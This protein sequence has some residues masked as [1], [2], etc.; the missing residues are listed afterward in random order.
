[1]TIRNKT[2]IDRWL[3]D[4]QASNVNLQSDG[5]TLTS[6]QDIIGKTLN[7]GAKIVIDKTAPA[8]A[9]MSVTTSRHVNMCKGLVDGIENPVTG[10][11]ELIGNGWG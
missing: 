11:V 2:I 4:Q 9:F 6:Y 8:G 3:N 1:M 7:N 5:Q 10:A